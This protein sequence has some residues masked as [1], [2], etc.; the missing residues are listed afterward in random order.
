LAPRTA[1]VFT[2]PADR[3]TV[4]VVES[5]DDARITIEVFGRRPT[6]DLSTASIALDTATEEYGVR[7]Q[8]TAGDSVTT[9]VHMH[10]RPWPLP[11][12]VLA[13]IT[14]SRITVWVTKN[15]AKLE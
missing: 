11:W 4:R 12:P 5:P 15:R 1:P 13:K 3:N 10:N 8:L 6:S 2:V 9:I 14:A 7:L